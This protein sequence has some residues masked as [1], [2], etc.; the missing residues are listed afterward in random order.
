MEIQFSCGYIKK[1]GDGIC[2]PPLAFHLPSISLFSRNPKFRNNHARLKFPSVR[3]NCFSRRSHR[4]C[5]AN[6]HREPTDA[7]NRRVSTHLKLECTFAICDVP[8]VPKVSRDRQPEGSNESICHTYSSDSATR[9][10]T[11]CVRIAGCFDLFFPVS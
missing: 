2:V 3:T 5:N 7:I 11:T 8:E 6:S 9:L 10:C 1:K 4:K